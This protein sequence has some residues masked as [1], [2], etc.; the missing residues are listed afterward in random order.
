MGVEYVYGRPN[1]GIGFRSRGRARGSDNLRCESIAPDWRK[2]VPR[3]RNVCVLTKP[4]NTVL[5]LKRRPVASNFTWRNHMRPS[6]GD[7]QSIESPL[8]DTSAV[9]MQYAVMQLTSPRT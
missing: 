9:S 2:P 8:V 7:F 5:F 6:R 4:G 1:C 3:Q